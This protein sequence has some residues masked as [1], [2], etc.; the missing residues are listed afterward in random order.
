MIIT[1]KNTDTKALQL[2]LIEDDD[3]YFG[4]TFTLKES[5]RIKNKL[6]EI[7]DNV[8]FNFVCRVKMPNLGDLYMSFND[9]ADETYFKLLSEGG[10][11]I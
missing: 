3:G 6:S 9:I 5:E 7:I 8:S 1:Y 2:I 10:L 4:S 11:E